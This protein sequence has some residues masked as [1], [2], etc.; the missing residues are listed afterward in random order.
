MA[1]WTKRIVGSALVAGGAGL[2]ASACADNESSI[3]IRQVIVPSSG[4]CAYAGDPGSAA[5][6][7]GV[8]D[9]AFR[10]EYVAG[11]LVGNQLV[12]RGSNEKIRTE[13]SRFRVEGSEVRIETPDGEV[14]RGAYTVPTA[15]FV[16][17]ASGTT[18]GWGVVSSVLIDSMTGGV[19]AA[20]GIGRVVSV[21]KVYGRTL[22][23]QELESGEFR[24]PISVCYGC[25]VSFP[26]EANDPTQT[27]VP[28]CLASSSSGSSVESPCLL[29]QDQPIDCR[30]CTSSG[31]PAD[32][33][34]PGGG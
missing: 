23:G 5:Y 31:Y 34:Q 33:C 20:S 30:V 14:L 15:G 3:F 27:P 12:Q 32:V 28:N 24:F 7:E 16:D 11:L 19:L 9:V 1:S 13:T 22:G 21:V 6:T 4:T 26:P 10:Q 17:P 29:G 18:P 8:L 25:L 2:L